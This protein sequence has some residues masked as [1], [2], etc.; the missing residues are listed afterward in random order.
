MLTTILRHVT[1][2]TIRR[3][4]GIMEKAHVIVRVRL[5]VL[6]VKGMDFMVGVLGVDRVLELSKNVS[7]IFQL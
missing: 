2:E 5:I 1:T 3:S 6:V 4:S 7:L